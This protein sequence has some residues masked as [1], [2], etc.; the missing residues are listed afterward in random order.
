MSNIFTIGTEL[1]AMQTR[2]LHADK[3]LE[4]AIKA[5]LSEQRDLIEK[6]DASMLKV[7]EHMDKHRI[8]LSQIIGGPS[9]D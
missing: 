5:V 4:E 6:I 8:A 9:N 2:I 1:E 3:A 7:A